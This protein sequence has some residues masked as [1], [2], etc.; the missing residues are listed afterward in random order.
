MDSYTPKPGGYVA[1]VYAVVDYNQP[2]LKIDNLSLSKSSAYYGEIVTV[3]VVTKNIGSASAGASTTRVANG[4]NHDFSVGVLAVESTQIDSF[5]YTCGASNVTFTATADINSVITESNEANN[6]LTNSLECIANPDLIIQSLSFSKNSAYEGEIVTL[7]VVTKNI[8]SGTAGESTTRVANGEENNFSV[9]SLAPGVNQSNSFNYTCG[10]S[11]VT[12]TA[13]ADINSVITESNEANNQQVNTLECRPKSDL[14]IDSIS[15]LEYIVANKTMV[16]V[17]TIVKN[18]GT[19]S[20][21]WFY[22]RLNTSITYPENAFISGLE[23]WS[24]KAVTKIYNCTAAHDFVAIADIT[25]RIPET[26]ET[27]NQLSTYIDCII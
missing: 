16:N 3:T 17:T 10:A 24:S 21:S 6:Q 12:F 2:D 20:V 7:T 25:G 8:G 22:T 14:I 13:T 26:D 5:N 23:P 18:N 19:S 11:N 9:A 27:N 15:F 4:G 1:Q